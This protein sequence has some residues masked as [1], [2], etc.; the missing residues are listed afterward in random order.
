MPLFSRIAKGRN[1]LEG[2]ND[3]GAPETEDQAHRKAAQIF[4][5]IFNI[6]TMVSTFDL[7]LAHYGK[8]IRESVGSF[9]QSLTGVASSSE[10]IS[11][12]TSQIIDANSELSE[13]ISRIAEDADILNQ[14]A[15]KSNEVLADIKAENAEMKV[16][17][18]NMDQSVQDLLN[19]IHKI[20]D[21]VKGINKISDQ[22]KLLSLNASI[23]A[24]RAGVAGKG[25]AVV[26]DEIRTLSGT[27]K[28]LTSNIDNLLE[29]M[30]GASGKSRA[31]VAKTLE[32][33]D[34]VSSSIEAVSGFMATSTETTGHITG[35]ITTVAETGK[36]IN[37]ALQESFTAL[38]QVNDDIQH[39]HGSAEE[40]SHIST[41]LNEISQTVA[42]IEDTINHMSDSSG[43]LVTSRY[44]GISNEDF[45]EVV[46]NAVNAHK[47]WMATAES[48]AAEMTVLPIQTDEHKCG[49]GHFYYSVR[50]ENPKMA[51]I[52]DS[53]EGFHHAMHKSG[54]ALIDCI[55]NGD[56]QRARGILAEAEKD[57]TAIIG[58][59]EQMIALTHDMSS[60]GERVF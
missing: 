6:A 54:D 27:T 32:S 9:N 2:E 16:F 28:Q 36:S 17:S 53:V 25:F 3:F 47:A 57:S 19:V 45:I 7:E 41:S 51:A 20:N 43:E 23:E 18:R 24:A 1:R 11:T 26:A 30:N 5:G 49:F 40:L 22:T 56:Q 35:R 10:E 4:K 58:K 33:I 29:E 46:K 8:K 34:K 59:F 55:R 21:A 15:V 12:S 14:N 60:N 42:R 13:T 38:E 37:N 50:P 31:S 44:C 52:W 39:L 48:M